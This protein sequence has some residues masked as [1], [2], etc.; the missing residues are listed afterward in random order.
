MTWNAARVEAELHR[1]GLAFRRQNILHG[2]QLRLASGE[3]IDVYP[4]GQV[5]LAGPDTPLAR[6]LRAIFSGRAVT[7]ES[8][9]AA[10]PFVRPP[11]RTRARAG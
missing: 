7:L 1:R 3:T 5:D 2:R 6:A 11:R 9:L 10:R 8:R 4:S